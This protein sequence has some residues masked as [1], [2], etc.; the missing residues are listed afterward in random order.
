MSERHS[1]QWLNWTGAS[2]PLFLIALH[3]L[4]LLFAT[5]IEFDACDCTEQ[6]NPVTSSESAQEHIQRLI[7]IRLQ[8][9]VATLITEITFHTWRSFI[10]A[11]VLFVCICRMLLSF[12]YLVFASCRVFTSESLGPST[13]VLPGRRAEFSLGAGGSH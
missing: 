4:R 5:C 12:I 11:C 6:S 2:S 8:A 13:D 3:Y 1:F 10:A 7:A 9:G